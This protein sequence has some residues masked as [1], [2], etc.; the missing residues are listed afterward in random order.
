M[1]KLPPFTGG[2]SNAGLL[3]TL[4]SPGVAAERQQHLLT[5]SELTKQHRQQQQLFGTA[6]NAVSPFSMPTPA[7]TGAFATSPT[8]LHSPVSYAAAQLAG[9]WCVASCCVLLCALAVLWFLSS[10]CGQCFNFLSTYYLACFLCTSVDW[11]V[12]QPH[13]TTCFTQGI[14]MTKP[15]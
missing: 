11:F 2:S 4:T 3:T 15:W 13:L 9:A 5:L 7:V 12:Y 14:R 1:D 6:S 8:Q 10:F